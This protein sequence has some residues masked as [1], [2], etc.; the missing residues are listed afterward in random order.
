MYD[1][2]AESR[3]I[4][5]ALRERACQV[6]PGRRLEVPGA[7]R[8]V[9][10]LRKPELLD[11]VLDWLALRPDVVG[12]DLFDTCR[13]LWSGS[14]REEQIFSTRLLAR[15]DAA[16]GHQDWST[17]LAWLDG[18]DSVEA[19]DAAAIFLVAPWVLHDFGPR[20]SNLRTLVRPGDLRRRRVALVA[21]TGLR[22]CNGYPDLVE[23]FARSVITDREPLVVDGLVWALC[24]LSR[25]HRAAV[26][27]VLRASPGLDPVAREQVG[28]WLRI[29]SRKGLV[30]REWR[31]PTIHQRG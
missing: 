18:A 2:D 26:E 29:G 3:L 14:T 16:L 27:S 17:V 4:A 23:D 31:I 24:A 15:R 30:P 11:A 8:E 1:A 20:L 7:A 6:P 28:N 13:H 10:G 21:T 22:K 5:R 25:H 12:Q 9:L 19:A